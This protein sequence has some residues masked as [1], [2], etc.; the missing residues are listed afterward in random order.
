MLQADKSTTYTKTEVGNSLAS[1]QM[2]LFGEIPATN[3]SWLFDYGDN[4]FRAI[5]VSSPLFIQTTN[6]A[7]LT[8]N[9]DCYTKTE[10]DTS[11]AL[12]ANQA[13]TYTNTEVDTSLALKA[14]KL[15]TYTKT[16]VDISLALKADT[17]PLVQNRSW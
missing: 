9:A 14:A 3:T 12:K 5:H 11:L 8:I 1:K 13:S 4:K 2:S 6:N 16:E 10:V 17:Q 15:T 7:Y